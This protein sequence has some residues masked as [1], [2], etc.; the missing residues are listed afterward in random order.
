MRRGTAAI[1]T[2]HRDEQTRCADDANAIAIDVLPFERRTLD[3]IRL[4]EGRT[5]FGMRKGLKLRG[6]NVRGSDLVKTIHFVASDVPTRQ[7]V[8]ADKRSGL[9]LGLGMVRSLDDAQQCC[10]GRD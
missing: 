4:D 7:R 10:V 3:G 1:Q 8:S 2:P 6:V 5:A 9:G